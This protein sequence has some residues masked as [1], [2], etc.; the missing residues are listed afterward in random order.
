LG[1]NT[2]YVAEKKIKTCIDFNEKAFFV[3]EFFKFT[4]FQNLRTFATALK[5]I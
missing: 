4:T 1:Q 5:I 3:L 2:S